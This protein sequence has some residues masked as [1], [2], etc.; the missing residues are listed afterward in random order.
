[1]ITHLSDVGGQGVVADVDVFG[2]PVDYTTQ[3]RGVEEGHWAL[4]H[5]IQKFLVHQLKTLFKGGFIV[6]L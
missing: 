3:G 4:H 2:K 1:M 5:P 6:E